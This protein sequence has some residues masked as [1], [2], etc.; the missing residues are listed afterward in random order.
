MDTNSWLPLEEKTYAVCPIQIV[1]IMFTYFQ[2]LV[3]QNILFL[4]NLKGSYTLIFR[5]GNQSWS[6]S[7][8]GFLSEFFDKNRIIL[9]RDHGHCQV[10]TGNILENCLTCRGEQF[11]FLYETPLGKQHTGNFS[12]FIHS[13][14]RTQK[15]F[16]SFLREECLSFSWVLLPNFVVECPISVLFSSL[17]QHPIQFGIAQWLADIQYFLVSFGNNGNHMTPFWSKIY[18][19]IHWG[20]LLPI[21]QSEMQWVTPLHHF[22]FSDHGH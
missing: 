14:A 5:S 21:F 1:G 18:K 2:K 22:S 8:M 11:L 10:S 13:I 6:L 16:C 17:V 9:L 4:Q 3:S 20:R 7:S 12:H 19:Q 15:D